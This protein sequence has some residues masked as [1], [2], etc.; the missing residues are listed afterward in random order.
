VDDI[1]LAMLEGGDLEVGA[2]RT[3]LRAAVQRQIMSPF[4]GEVLDVRRAV[5]IDGSDYDR[6]DGSGK[7]RM[8]I[9]TAAEYDGLIEAQGG[10]KALVDKLGY[11]FDV[12]DGRELFK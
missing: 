6:A 2:K 8:Y 5:L 9:M 4:G 3:I 12:L 11:K 1:M 10:V 7:G